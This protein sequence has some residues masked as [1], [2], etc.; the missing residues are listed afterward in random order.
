MITV[1]NAQISQS[2]VVSI[3]L[4]LV[5]CGCAG[6]AFGAAP[7]EMLDLKVDIGALDANNVIPQ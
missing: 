7:D 3:L 6:L 5:L 1:I 2:R 4:V